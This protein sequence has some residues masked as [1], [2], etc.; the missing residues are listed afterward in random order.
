[1]CMNAIELEGIFN[2]KKHEISWIEAISS[3]LKYAA[4]FCSQ[5]TYENDKRCQSAAVVQHSDS[6]SKEEWKSST[7]HLLACRK[8]ST[9][10]CRL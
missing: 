7:K 5:Y 1:M 3:V 2:I 6:D 10:K 4:C 8:I 9:Y